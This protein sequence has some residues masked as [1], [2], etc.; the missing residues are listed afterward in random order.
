MASFDLY[1][2]ITDR[3]VDM[4]E[5][6]VRP[7]E[8]PWEGGACASRPLRWNGVPYRGVNTLILWCEAA[9]K[10]FNNPTWMSYKQATDLGGQVRKGEKSTMI[11]FYKLMVNEDANGDE[12]KFPLLRYSN[13]FNV[14]QIDGLPA[15]YYKVAE[16]KK[17]NNSKRNKKV[18]EFFKNYGVTTKHGGNSAMYVPSRD[19]IHMPVF[20]IFTSADTYY[21]T[22]AH[23][24]IHSTRHETRL[25]RDFGRKNWGDAGYAMEELVAEMGAAFLCADLGITPEVRE[26]HAQYIDHW[27]KVMKG[28]KRAIFTASTAAT[29]AVEFMHKAQPGYAEKGQEEA[30]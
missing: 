28:D 15:K 14:D 10:G 30:A 9:D 11:V 2:I 20:E 12:K 5:A 1:Q 6:G 3:I 19:E 8:K 29:A 22:L 23:E 21:S 25:K 16:V 24:N 26:D 13:V 4:L 18:D 17:I 27:L 7:W